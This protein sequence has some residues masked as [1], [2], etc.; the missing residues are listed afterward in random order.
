[1]EKSRRVVESGQRE[2]IRVKRCFGSVWPQT[3]RRD[4]FVDH[5][6][7][8]FVDLPRDTSA[9]NVIKPLLV[10]FVASLSQSHIFHLFH[11]NQP[12]SQLQCLA[13]LVEKPSP[14]ARHRVA[15]ASRASLALRKLV[16][17]SLSVVSIVFLSVATMPSV[18][19]QVHLVCC[20]V[21]HVLVFL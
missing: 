1:M 16:S 20:S 5:Q 11:N 7:L 18:W 17:S 12:I 13:S 19:V 3:R 4:R 6:T 21:N 14:E 10:F 15:T 8:F 9:S 2:F